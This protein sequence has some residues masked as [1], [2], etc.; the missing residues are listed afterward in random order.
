MTKHLILILVGKRKDSALK[1]Q[2]IL[3]EWGCMIKTRLGVHDGVLE[4]CSDFGLM[5]L[6][7]VGDKNN[8]EEVARKLNLLPG[9]EAKYVS[10]TLSE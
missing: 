6:E 10:L 8:I 9:V 7:V 4:D 1:V 2:Q 3:T 5:V